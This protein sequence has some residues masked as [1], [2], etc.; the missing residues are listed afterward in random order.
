MNFFL[1]IDFISAVADSLMFFLLYEA[2]MRRRVA[3]TKQIYI[4]GVLIL[5][6]GIALCNYWFMLTPF[7]L[8]GMGILSFIASFIYKSTMWLRGFVIVLGTLIGMMTEMITLYMSAFI[9]DITVEM[10]IHTTGC[11][12]LGIILSKTISL[13]ICNLIRLKSKIYHQEVNKTYWKMFLLLFANLIVVDLFVFELVYNIHD[14][15]LNTA[16]VC[17]SICMTLSTIIA[18]YIYEKQGHQDYAMKLQEQN[19]KYLKI[20]LKHLADLLV[21]QEETKRLRHD[22]TNQLI[23]LKGYLRKG[24][25]TDGIAHVDALTDLLSNSEVAIDT[26]NIALDAIINTKKA[27]AESKEIRVET[28]IQ[29]PEGLIL[30]SV[31]I[32]VIF[33]NALDNAI[34][35]CARCKNEYKTISVFLVQHGTKLLCRISN[36]I[37]VGEEVNLDTT[38]GDKDNHG[39]G[40]IN[41]REALEKYN[42][43]PIFEIERGVFSLKFVIFEE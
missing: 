29:I 6:V 23:A 5:A 19:K 37:D 21:Q 12:S 32:C 39:F 4:L 40:L 8:L 15:A 17:A 20:Q 10:M 41:I 38:K 14:S 22:M 2:F 31:D 34:E 1:T 26:G 27:L 13:F 33:G 7:N 36:T 16:A 9:L 28:T 3:C 42:S 25:M 18:L 24:Q 35:A 43:E 11:R 30:D